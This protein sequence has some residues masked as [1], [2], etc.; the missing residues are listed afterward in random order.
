MSRRKIAA[1]RSIL[2]DRQFGS[3]LV[4]KFIN[5]LMMDGK[6]SIS[7]RI[8]YGA[9]EKLATR[10][11]GEPLELF[12]K[13]IENVKPWVEV[14]SRRVGGATYQIPVDVR[15]VRR[16]TLAIRWLVESARKRPEK[17]MIDRLAR[18]LQD[19]FENKGMAIKIR[20]DKEKMAQANQA[21]AS[22]RW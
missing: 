10:L 8:F 14:R 3:E 20:Q 7:E 19:A 5:H 9:V 11:K 2:P 4:S 17:G 12:E 1:K 21:F 6:K 18:E 22:Y 13:A 16:I 15:P